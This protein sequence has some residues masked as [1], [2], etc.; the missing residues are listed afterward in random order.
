MAYTLKSAWSSR[1]ITC[2]AV[3]QDNTTIKDFVA[4][5]SIS[6]G[7]GVAAGVGTA[8][9]KGNTRGYFPTFANGTFNYHGITY[10]ATKPVATQGTICSW[11]AILNSYTSS[12]GWWSGDA[13][14]SGGLRVSSNKP[15]LSASTNSIVTGATSLAASTKQSVMGIF[16][17]AGTCEIHYGL[18]SGSMAQD[19]TATDSGPF[20]GN[21][22]MDGYGGLSG[23]GNFVGNTHLFLV[24]N[25]VIDNTDRDALHSDFV[26]TLFDTGSASAA[27]VLNASYRRRRSVTCF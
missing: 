3:D 15:R 2:I 11:F 4:A 1:V 5:N 9:Y 8:T 18:E 23:Q 14:A 21:F 19:A 16:R 17:R 25:D 12:S 24:T 10:N 13:A 6:L 22:S 26:G 7:T 27:P 20:G